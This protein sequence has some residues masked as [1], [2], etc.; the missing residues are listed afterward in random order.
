MTVTLVN[1]DDVESGV[2]SQME[3]HVRLQRTEGTFHCRFGIHGTG[4]YT[5]D[6][7]GN[8]KQFF[9]RKYVKDTATEI[10]II[11][12]NFGTLM[13]K[14]GCRDVRICFVTI[15]IIC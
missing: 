10:S 12:N 1:D 8:F 4:K 9:T 14:E 7:L 6:I 5:N 2:R 15:I 3:R 11:K 13:I